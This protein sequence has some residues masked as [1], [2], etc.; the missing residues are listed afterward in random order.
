[1][2]DYGDTVFVAIIR[3]IGCIDKN[4]TGIDEEGDDA[5]GCEKRFF[6]HMVLLLMILK[7]KVSLFHGPLSMDSCFPSKLFYVN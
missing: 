5:T 1:M 6:Q 3:F 4:S 7:T 2:N